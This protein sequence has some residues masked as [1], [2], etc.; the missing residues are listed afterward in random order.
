V[1][2]SVQLRRQTSQD[3]LQILKHIVVPEAYDAKS[4]LREPCVSFD[5]SRRLGMLTAI[6]LNDQSRFETEEVCNVRPNRNLSTEFE[7]VESAIL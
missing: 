7:C 3:A 6:D 2:G 1:R 5:I 4:V